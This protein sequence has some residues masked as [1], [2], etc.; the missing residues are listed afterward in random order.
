M[1]QGLFIFS[2]LTFHPYSASDTHSKMRCTL[3][4]RNVLFFLTAYYLSVWNNFI[5]NRGVLWSSLSSLPALPIASLIMSSLNFDLNNGPFF[6][7]SLWGLAW[8]NALRHVHLNPYI[9]IP[10]NLHIVPMR[11]VH[12]Q[13]WLFFKYIR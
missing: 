3:Y 11:E 8:V 1:W 6:D 7:L 4:Q 10:K 5:T 9:Y 13:G 2:S 12:I